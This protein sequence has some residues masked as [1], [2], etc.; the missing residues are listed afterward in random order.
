MLST[1]FKNTIVLSVVA[2]VSAGPALG[3]Q[4]RASDVCYAGES[5][6][7]MC[8][9]RPQGTPQDIRI[10]DVQYAAAALHNYA[11]GTD[12][13]TDKNGNPILDENGL[14]M[15]KTVYRFLNMTTE[16]AADCGEWTIYDAAQTVLVTAKLVSKTQGGLVWYGDIANSIDGSGNETV[17]NCGTDG[18]SREVIVNTSQPAYDQYKVE[19]TRGTY[20][21]R[22]NK[23]RHTFR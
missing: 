23:C 11:T 10:A 20:S 13:L 19:Y 22:R 16:T 21:K 15:E 2:Q 1:L 8:Y 3:S 5:V 6:K 4:P 9:R 12:E 7:Y 14:P 17:V 18:G